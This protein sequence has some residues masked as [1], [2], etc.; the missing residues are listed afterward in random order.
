MFKETNHNFGQVA[1]GSLTEFRFELQ[2]S[3]NETVHISGVRTS[4][5]CTTPIIEKKTLKTWETG[6]IIAHFNTDTFTGQKGA[7]LT[8]TI[9]QPF[10]AE[11]QLR[12]DGF[13]RTDVNFQPGSVNFGSVDQGESKT[14]QIRVTHYGSNNWAISD[15]RS[16]NNH[17]SVS[18]NEVSRANGTVAYDMQVTLKDDAP[19]G[20]IQDQINVVTNDGN[21]ALIPLRVEGRIDSSLTLSPAALFVGV[22]KPGEEA[23]K[24]LI[25]RGKKP[26]VI[27]DVKCGNESFSFEKPTGDA[28]ALQFLPIK[29]TAPTKGG[30]IS[31][32]IEIHTDA[33]VVVCEA[34]ATVE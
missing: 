33:G 5:G 23:S 6:A 29:F 11:V 32:R 8:V 14:T 2:N 4:C 9:D 30:K 28:K 7:T 13:I 24:Q 16:G 25:V 21:R 17:L 31:D 10:Y 27:T 12:V 20:Y 15:V 26:F 22:M 1:R 18:L 3:Y 34:T 19:S